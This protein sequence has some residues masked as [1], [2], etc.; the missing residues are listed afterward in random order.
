VAGPR[1]GRP[2]S[3]EAVQL[4]Q[5]LGAVGV[6]PVARPG[7]LR[8]GGRQTDG[9]ARLHGCAE[10]GIA[11]ELDDRPAVAGVGVPEQPVLGGL[12]QPGGGLGLLVDDPLPFSGRLG[13]HELNQLRAHLLGE[14]GVGGQLGRLAHAL[15]DRLGR[16]EGL[17]KPFEVAG[18]DEAELDPAP[19]L[20]AVVADLGHRLGGGAALGHA[21]RITDLL[22]ASADDFEGGVEEGHLDPLSRRAPFAGHQR[23][24]DPV[25]RRDGREA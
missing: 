24:H 17:G 23:R 3:L 5:D 7:G 12:A 21:G 11:V 22:P 18:L 4:G 19:V 8:R 6:E 15:F 13:L 14:L 25:A 1:A 10:L 9:V 2:L 20:A 16:E